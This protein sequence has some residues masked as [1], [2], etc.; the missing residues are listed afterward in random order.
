MEDHPVAVGGQLHVHGLRRRRRKRRQQQRK[1]SGWK[2]EW[3]GGG[4]G[5]LGGTVTR[6]SWLL[7]LVG[8][9]FRNKEKVWAQPGEKRSKLRVE[10][11]SLRVHHSLE[12]NLQRG[13]CLIMWQRPRD[14]THQ[15]DC[16]I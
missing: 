4:A 13:N 9:L 11:K 8:F 12:L 10:G 3:S 7:P 14:D 5:P 1:K 2:K 6:A 16:V 15:A